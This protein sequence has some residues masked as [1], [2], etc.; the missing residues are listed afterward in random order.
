MKTEIHRVSYPAFS[1]YLIREDALVLVDAG[2]ARHGAELLGRMDALSLPHQISLLLLTHGHWDHIGSANE[3]RELT[4]CKVAVHQQDREW[5]ERGFRPTPPA[6]SAWG[7]VMGALTERMFR[8]YM[9]LPGTPIDVVVDSEELSLQPFGIRGRALHTPGHSAGSMSILLDSGD[10]F[11][12]D[13]VMNGWFGP[14]MSPWVED[15]ATVRESW[16]L[17][18]NKGAK[19]IY[20][21]HWKPFGAD[22]LERLVARG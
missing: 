1:C 12:G 3:I 7:R 18:L 10:A 11:V 14:S 5:V 9:N 13:L 6:A 20:P 4:G 15:A 21:A 22:R 8:S 16:R 17:L 19:R 2:P